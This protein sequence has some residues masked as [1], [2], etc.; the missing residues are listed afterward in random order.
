[1]NSEEKEIS[2]TTTNTYSTLNTYTSSTKNVWLVCHGLGY[3]SRYFINHFK[4]LDPDKNYIIAPQAQSKFYLKSNFKHVGSCWLTKEK[5]VSETQNIMH[6]IDAVLKNE[7]ISDQVNLFVLGF[8]QGVSIA[9]RY[10][11]SRHLTCAKLILHSGGIPKELTAD[12]FNFFTGE[13]HV[14]YGN[15]DNYLNPERLEV[16]LKQ[17]RAIFKNHLNIIPFNGTH[18]ID[19]NT[20]LELSK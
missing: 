17:A 8:S 11:A 20:I 1:M 2:Y 10:V 6:Y 13:T 12:H 18:E 9:A 14:V 16:E 19:K 7:K 3:L 4:N 15:N 5:T